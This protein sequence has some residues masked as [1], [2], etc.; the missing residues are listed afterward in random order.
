MGSSWTTRSFFLS[1]CDPQSVFSNRKV[2]L[3]IEAFSSPRLIEL[4]PKSTHKG[5]AFKREQSEHCKMR[6]PEYKKITDQRS[7]YVKEGAIK[8]ESKIELN[9][10]SNNQV[11]IVGIEIEVSSV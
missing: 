6:N 8:I 9:T 3:F 10:R 7:T 4:N 5:K 1:F 2:I 11:I